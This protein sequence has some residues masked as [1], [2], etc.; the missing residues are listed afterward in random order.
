MSFPTIRTAEEIKELRAV[1]DHMQETA[2][3]E[4]PVDEVETITSLL[5]WLFN[6][7]SKNE[8]VMDLIRAQDLEQ[9]M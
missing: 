8:S 6:P 5:A 3:E 9:Y 4:S 2:S 7:S 1:F